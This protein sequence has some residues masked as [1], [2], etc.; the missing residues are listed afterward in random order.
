MNLLLKLLA[1]YRRVLIWTLLGA[2][3]GLAYYRLV[4]CASGACTILSDPRFTAAYG[5]VLGALLSQV[6]RRE[7]HRDREEGSS[8]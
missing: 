4:G 7:P 2:A 6:F 5:A 1:R 8:T 3:A